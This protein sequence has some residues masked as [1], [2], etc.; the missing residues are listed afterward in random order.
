MHVYALALNAGSSSLKLG[1]CW[2]PEA[3]DWRLESRGQIEGIGTSPRLSARDAAG[4]TAM[5]CAT[6]F[7]AA[8]QEQGW[9]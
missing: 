8:S 3:G 1:L 9:R 2:R 5:T 7:K 4:R 6:F